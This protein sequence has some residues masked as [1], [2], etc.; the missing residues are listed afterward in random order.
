MQLPLPVSHVIVVLNDKTG[1]KGYGGANHD[2]AFSYN[3]ERE[4]PLDTYGGYTFQ[5]GIVHEIAHYYWRVDPDWIDEGVANTFEYLHGVESGVS[6]G[7]LERAHRENCEAHDL[8]M[9]TKWNPGVEDFDRFHCNY[10]LGQML[11]HELL[12]TLG[13]EGFN[14]RLRELYRLSLE[15]KD[16]GD[17]PGIADVK[18]AFHDQS[19]IVENH[20]SGK[21]NAPENRPIDEGIYRRNHGLVQWDQYPTYNGDSVSFT[22]TLLGDAVLS[23]ET[24]HEARKGGYQ[25]FLLYNAD[26]S[27][28]VGTIL[29]PL[30]D[31]QSWTLDDPGD[32]TAIEYNLEER[33]FKVRF[34][35]RR[36]LG[37]PSDYVVSVSG[38]QDE[39]RVPFIGEKIDRLGYARIRVE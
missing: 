14:E 23:K 28:Y 24:I 11:F 3:P 4:Q 32:T 12:E 20:W 19:E 38:F 9:L 15:V 17:T 8:E 18:Q 10:F 37:S 26:E 22:G 31:G 6:Q 2:Y 7:L 36:G 16:A 25:N 5:S 39:N 30:N 29:P 1:S 33:T 35:L 27:G 21:L 34:R 13:A